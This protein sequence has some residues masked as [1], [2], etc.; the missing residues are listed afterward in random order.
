MQMQL[1]HIVNYTKK[2]HDIRLAYDM[3]EL[4]EL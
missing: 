4:Y 2:K 1:M 3:Y